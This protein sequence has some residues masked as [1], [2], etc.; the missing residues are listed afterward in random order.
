MADYWVIVAMRALYVAS[1]YAG[2][3]QPVLDFK[4]GRI[5]CKNGAQLDDMEDLPKASKGFDHIKEMFGPNRFNMS[6]KEM[7]AIMGAH[8]LG[9]VK[10]ASSGYEGW[11]NLRNLIFDNS[12]YKH[13]IDK[14][15]KYAHATINTPDFGLKYQWNATVDQCVGT[16]CRPRPAR[17]PRMM[18]NADMSIY[19]NFIV[20]SDG[21]PSCSYE[22]CL[23]FLL[24]QLPESLF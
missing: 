19:L 18:L 23:Y 8:S 10:A 22:T 5:N 11:W 20:G 3:T 16:N 6:I 17:H 9:E 7:V 13:M 1:N 15:L 24:N 4:Y 21:Q 12:Y 2:L 14:T